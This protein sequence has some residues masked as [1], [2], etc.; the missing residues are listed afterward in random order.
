MKFSG[1]VFFLSLSSFEM[2]DWSWLKVAGFFL[3]SHYFFYSDKRTK[4]GLSAPPVFVD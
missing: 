4:L 1:R 2:K 3:E